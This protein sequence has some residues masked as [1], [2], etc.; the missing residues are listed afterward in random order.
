MLAA[1]ATLLAACAG[2][3]AEP[4]GPSTG[5]LRPAL[6]A[7]TAAPPDVGPGAPSCRGQFTS[8]IARQAISNGIGGAARAQGVTVPELQALISEFCAGP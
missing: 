4:T 3:P 6:N 8:A 1:V 7:Q 2:G 5:D